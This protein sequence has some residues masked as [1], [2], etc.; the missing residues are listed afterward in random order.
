[1]RPWIICIA[2][3]LALDTAA[4]A[5]PVRL[6]P[7]PASYSGVLHCA[8]C[9]GI[10]HQLNLLPGGA[11]M[12]ALSYFK[13]G[14]DETF[15]ELGSWSVSPDSSVLTLDSGAPSRK[16]FTLKGRKVIRPLNLES[17]PIESR[18]PYDLRRE[19]KLIPMEPRLT[20]R[21]S[22]FF[23]ADAAV[24]T[25][26]ASGLRW[27]VAPGAAASELE[28]AFIAET[29]PKRANDKPDERRELLLSLEGRVAARPPE[30]IEGDKPTL[31][32]ERFLEAFPGETCGARGVES[33]FEG[34]RW[35]LTRIGHEPVRLAAEQREAFMAFDT[36]SARVTGFTGCNRFNGPF[37]RVAAGSG[38]ITFGAIVS[39]RMA[40]AGTNLE[41]PFLEALGKVQCY[42]ITGA[43][44]D[45]LDDQRASVA[46]FEARDL[47]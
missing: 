13:R 41:T 8:D 26:C 6:G 35:V 30:G 33:S 14:H 43:H 5:A 10:R 46:R 19:P 42:R 17:R 21:G 27:P 31:I 39:T 2:V 25:D 44:L 28:K 34:T 4:S 29:S 1:M 11:Y 38:Q 40:C 3:T 45:L 12:Q 9:A 20:L 32:V 23:M 7:L 15:H 16:Q 18:L 37:T 24:F 47:H 36:K 22:Y